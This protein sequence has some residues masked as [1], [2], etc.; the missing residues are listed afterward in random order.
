MSHL[1]FVFQYLDFGGIKKMN[2]S[3]HATNQEEI[4]ELATIVKV[5][6]VTERIKQIAVTC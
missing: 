1:L 6:V 4:D 5:F 2:I 3:C